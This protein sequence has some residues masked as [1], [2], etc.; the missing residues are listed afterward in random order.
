MPS[1][2]VRTKKANNLSHVSSEAFAISF[3]DRSFAIYLRV[4]LSVALRCC[5]ASLRRAVRA[6][7]AC[8]VGWSAVLPRLGASL[9]ESSR[10][11]EACS[12]T[13]HTDGYGEQSF[14]SASGADLVSI[15]G[16]SFP[17]QCLPP[18]VL[19]SRYLHA[20]SCSYSHCWKAQGL[21]SRPSDDNRSAYGP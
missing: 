5:V 6:V 2:E 11:T 16:S 9:V 14:V 19:I 1:T 3:R 17:F 7:V 15:G 18:V 21:K 20:V 12:R 13:Q 8:C 10:N 4:S